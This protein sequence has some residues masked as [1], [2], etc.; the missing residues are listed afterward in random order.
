MDEGQADG[1]VGDHSEIRTV[2]VENRTASDD[3]RECRGS[4]AVRSI[5]SS[6]T[7]NDDTSV[8]DNECLVSSI[9][10]IAAR[11]SNENVHDEAPHSTVGAVWTNDSVATAKELDCNKQS[12]KE[13][14]SPPTTRQNEETDIESL[15]L[16]TNESMMETSVNQRIRQQAALARAYVLANNT[17][18]RSG[19]T[20]SS[21]D[22]SVVDDDEIAVFNAQLVDGSVDQPRVTAAVEPA[23]PLL[24]EAKPMPEMYTLRDLLR[25]RKIRCGI[26]LL[27]MIVAGSLVATVYG[28]VGLGNEDNDSNGRSNELS[29]LYQSMAPSSLT[30]SLAPISPEELTI[31]RFVLVDAEFNLDITELKD[32]ETYALHQNLAINVRAETDGLV[33]SVRFDLNGKIGESMESVWP[34]ALFGDILGDYGYWSGGSDSE[35]PLG[36]HIVTATP[37]SKGNG[38][39]IKGPSKTITFTFVEEGELL[40]IFDGE[41]EVEDLIPS[42]IPSMAPSL[43]RL[44]SSTPPISPEDLAISALVLVNAESNTD[45]IELKDDRTYTTL[46]RDPSLNIRAETIGPVASV[47]FEWNGMVDNTIE[48]TRPYAMFGDIDGDYCNWW[49]PFGIHVVRAT[50][51]SEKFGKGV[52]GPSMTITFI[53]Q[54]EEPI[55]TIP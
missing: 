42:V 7:T 24:C 45:M 48:N 3:E 33:K 54:A 14:F 12:I 37:Y 16:T 43:I 36:S 53:I 55:S 2:F 26:V 38:N 52:K 34:Y 28:I 18:R 9:E 49:A 35:L 32:G 8:D 22:D 21:A 15:I 13:N 41:G 29:N 40:D 5:S 30:P 46:S 6:S 51:Y 50:P 10:A 11:N 47:S 27:L 17:L 44:P 1:S 31:S 4:N 19:T 23:A 20:S 39:G 25:Q